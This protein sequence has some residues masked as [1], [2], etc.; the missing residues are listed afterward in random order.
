MAKRINVSAS[1]P[2]LA[3][4]SDRDGV[5]QS[6]N[7][8]LLQ[9]DRDPVLEQKAKKEGKTVE[10]YQEYYKNESQETLL[11]ERDNWPTFYPYTLS[12]EQIV[13]EML[14]H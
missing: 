13:A 7:P 4:L 1:Y 8:Y 12:K 5:W 6:V 14:H 11:N 3:A 2:G 10:E 9:G